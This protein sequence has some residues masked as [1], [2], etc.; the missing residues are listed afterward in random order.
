VSTLTPYNDNAWHHAVGTQGSDGLKFYVDGKLIGALPTQTTAQ[1]YW[2]SWKLGGDQ[3]NGWPLRPT[4]NYFAG[5]LDE[6]AVYPTVLSPTQVS[7]HYA[8]GTAP[9]PDTQAPAAVTGV[10]AAV[11]GSDVAVSWGASSDNVGVT[12]YEVHRSATSGFTPSA[13]SRVATV[14]GNTLNWT[15]AGRPAGTSYYKVLA[16]DAASNVSGP[17]NEATATVAPK[18]QPV[19][20]TLTPTADTYV[21]EAFPNNVSGSLATLATRGSPAYITYLRFNASSQIPAGQHLASASLRFR[22]TGDSYAGSADVQQTVM[23]TG[24]WSEASTNYTNRP[25]TNGPQI[26]AFAGPT[27][28]NA[29]YTASLDAAALS[30]AL[31]GDINLS[32]QGSGPDN[33]WFFSRE[34]AAARQPALVLNFEPNA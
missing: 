28:P 1:S 17:S 34:A 21:N 11:N 2:G 32:L 33:M 3:M 30:A 23:M 19:T 16:T 25:Q 4:S 15:D 31:A 9:A 18:P 24:D 8:I 14:D 10:V 5:S 20:L 22:T 6:F 26:G 12:G 27:A 13:A 7:E 29:T